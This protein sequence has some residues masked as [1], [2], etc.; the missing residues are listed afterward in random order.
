VT[1]SNAELLSGEIAD[2]FAG[3]AVTI[4]VHPLSYD[5]FLVFHSLPDDDDSLRQYLRFGGSFS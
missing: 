4:E 2:R 1:G 3:R 5:E